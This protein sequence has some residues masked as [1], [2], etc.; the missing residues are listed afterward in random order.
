MSLLILRER[1][2]L[3]SQ[4]SIQAHAFLTMHIVI[5]HLTIR[6]TVHIKAKL[7]TL[8]YKGKSALFA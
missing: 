8:K 4:V 3:N 1:P 5:V 7:C 6:Q 2:T